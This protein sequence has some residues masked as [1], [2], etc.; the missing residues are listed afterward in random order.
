M[1][2]Q[3]IKK[4][5]KNQIN[6]LRAKDFNV[7]I[8]HSDGGFR[9]INE[10]IQSF[11]IQH[12]MCAAGV[13]VRIVERKIRVIK[14]R[15]R[16]ILFSLPF[17]LPNSL[18]PYLVTFATRTINMITTANSENN[19]APF[20]N[21]MCR[22]INYDIDLRIYFGLYCQV[23]CADTNN[24]MEQRTTGAIALTQ[25]NNPNGAALFYDLNTKKVIYRDKW[26]EVPISQDVIDRVNSIAME[27]KLSPTKNP[28]IKVGS[29]SR[30]LDEDFIEEDGI[31]VLPPPHRELIQP[32]QQIIEIE[33]DVAQYTNDDYDSEDEDSD[34][35]P[36]DQEDEDFKADFIE[37]VNT[38]HEDIKE[39][40]SNPNESEVNITP[41]VTSTLDPIT[42]QPIL[43]TERRYPTR[44]NRGRHIPMYGY[45][46]KAKRFVQAFG[47]KGEEAID[48]ELRSMVTKEVFTPVFYDKLAEEEKKTIIPSF[49]F[50]KEKFKPSGELDKI[51]AR[52]VAGGN[53]QNK[54][55]FPNISSPTANITHIFIEATLSAA[56]E[57]V[58][59]SADIGTAYLNAIMKD[60]VLMMLDKITTQRLIKLYPEFEKFVN[61]Y[62]K[63]IVKLNK[64]LYG[65]VQSALL[66]YEC[67]REFLLR[68]GFTTNP[69]DEC[70]FTRNNDTGSC[71]IIV[72]V[73]D[74]LF[75]ASSKDII[76]EVIQCLRSE[77]KDINVNYGNVI[78][79]LGMELSFDRGK[80]KVTMTGYIKKLL[81]EYNITSTS[82]TPASNDL[83]TIT[84][85]PLL[86]NDKKKQLH[87]LTAQLLFLSMRARPD[88]LL[89][90]NFLSTRVNSYN[91][92][93]EEK[94][95][96]VLRY[97][98]G[99]ID[100][101]LNLQSNN[102]D[103]VAVI[104]STDASYGVHVDG[105]G[106]T[107]IITSFGNGS[108]YSSTTK[109][110]L[111]VKSSSEGELTAASDGIS[112]IMS[113]KNYLISRGYNVSS[114][115]LLQ[116][117]MSTQ[118]IIKNGIK[119]ARRSRHLN[120]RY[121]FIKQFVQDNQIRVEHVSTKDMVADILTKPLQGQQFINL[122]DK[123]LGYLPMANDE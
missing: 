80:L 3:A 2:S 114:L 106:Q 76:E 115:K 37:D 15:M 121:F 22:R 7:S 100:L 20:E 17:L 66:W 78:S 120:I 65:C 41:E 110:K 122:R 79:Y 85:E 96:R 57:D 75:M 11:G 71:T 25:T 83:F 35:I 26:K 91:K 69:Y 109:Q 50:L 56:R 101:G 36:S 42:E 16:T 34:Y 70:I 62:G 123:L 87:S 27:E 39:S 108:I 43:P 58:R 119:S 19:L 23:L 84:D 53:H 33:P 89:P 10:F 92:C 48:C 60:Q 105:K 95:L 59:A 67:L 45:H 103:K 72:Y 38:L 90:V 51:K 18:I 88:I 98:C 93:D 40:G 64:A 55:L 82:P 28:K 21:F 104:T 13:H 99:T 113:I 5:V 97:L 74:L 32:N 73:D 12:Q 117:N 77:F 81:K 94:A 118:S 111:V 107:G 54:K 24:S 29:D 31:E 4:A 102:I 30:K 52:L 1:K 86:A 46:V 14:E 8:V 6:L 112:H 61:R 9:S 68:I 47:T 63:I 116:D 44:N 49:I